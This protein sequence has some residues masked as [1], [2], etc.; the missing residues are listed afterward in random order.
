[1][2]KQAKERQT[3][4][5]E[6]DGSS[7]QTAEVEDDKI[8]LL[9]IG[10][11]GDHEILEVEQLGSGAVAFRIINNLK[12]ETYDPEA[13]NLEWEF[14]EAARAVFTVD[15]EALDALYNW[16]EAKVFWTK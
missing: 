6:T 14:Y 16:L 1:M 3:I 8:T 5:I 9:K 7:Y 12:H 13:G 4:K 2:E 10:V 11:P 15:P